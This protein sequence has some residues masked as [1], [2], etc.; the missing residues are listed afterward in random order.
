[1][2]TRIE[3]LIKNQENIVESLNNLNT[4][5]DKLCALLISDQILEE[6]VSLEGEVRTPAQ[7]AEIIKNS[8]G[9]GLCLSKDLDSDHRSFQYSVSEFFI[10]EDDDDSE[11]KKD[12]SVNVSDTF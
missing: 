4:K 1:M 5:L 2:T 9:A 8:F 12:N 11:N 6:A 7:C 3:R 10:D